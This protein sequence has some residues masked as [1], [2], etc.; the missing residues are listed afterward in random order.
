MPLEWKAG[1]DLEGQAKTYDIDTLIAGHTNFGALSAEINTDNT[2]GE[3]GKKES[4]VGGI[5]VRGEVKKEKDG[6]IF[7]RREE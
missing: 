7:L 1:E 6:I 2:H 4:T 3:R 5:I